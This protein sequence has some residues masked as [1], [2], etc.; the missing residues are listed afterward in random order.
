MDCLK[1]TSTKSFTVGRG[2]LLI[3]VTCVPCVKAVIMQSSVLIKS[4]HMII[5]YNEIF[6]CSLADQTLLQSLCDTL[7]LVNKMA[8]GPLCDVL[9]SLVQGILCFQSDIWFHGTQV[10]VPN[11]MPTGR[12]WP[13]M[14]LVY[15]AHTCLDSFTC[16]SVIQNFTQIGQPMW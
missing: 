7:Y 15:K 9:H 8:N 11:A 12:V 13:P 3:Y 6:R 4:Q 1:G 2:A 5:N 14:F 10:N 16:S